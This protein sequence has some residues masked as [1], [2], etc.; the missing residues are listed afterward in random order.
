LQQFIFYSGIEL[1]N[2]TM[3][4][5]RFSLLRN[6]LHFV[7][8]LEKPSDCTDKFYKTRPLIDIVRKFCLELPLEEN[9]SIDE[10]IVP[11]KGNLS[12]KQYMKGK[13]SPWGI[14]I[15]V[16]CGQSGMPYDFLIYQGATTEI[17][18][19]FLKRFGFGG[20]VVLHL[21]KRISEPGHKLYFDNYFSNYQ[22]FEI[23][24]KLK[25]NAAGTLR[26]NRFAN[27]PFLTDRETKIKGRGHAEEVE[28]RDGNVVLTKWQDSK[29]VI[30]GSN[31]VGKGIEKIVSRWDKS[32]KEYVSVNQ[33]EVIQLYNESMGGV[34]LLDQLLSYYRIFIKSKKW[35]LRIISHFIDFA[36]CISWIQYKKSLKKSHVNSKYIMDLLNFRIT[37]AKELASVQHINRKRGRPR[38]DSES[39]SRIS[40]SPTSS[41]KY[42]KRPLASVQYDFFDH[43][44]S[45]DQKPLPSRCK[46]DNCAFQ[47]HLFCE[48]CQVH[49]CLNRNR[50]CFKDFHQKKAH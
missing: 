16:L 34:D 33:P 28:S 32:K 36:V 47:S 27:P 31:F 44:P 40:E 20:A 38:F 12:I 50:N 15:F 24:K 22:T 37:L 6:N 42:E 13:P 49:L 35:T 17:T 19:G 48:K 39:E 7:D 46:N 9:L 3:S 1:M 21:S 43:M 18:P 45:H 4:C 26:L 23:L 25:I 29:P 8:N 41:K 11:F 5:E 14:K 2:D 30:M 10:Q